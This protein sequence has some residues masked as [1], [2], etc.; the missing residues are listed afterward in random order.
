MTTFAVVA[1]GGM[2]AAVGARLVARGARV[3]TSTAG[4]SLASIE[5]AK[6]AGMH[7]VGDDELATADV[8]LSI[9]PPNQAIDL[10]ERMAA[11]FKDSSHRPVYIDLNAVSPETACRTEAVVCASG[12]AFVDGGIIGMPPQGEGA[13]PVFYLSG[14]VGSTLDML[15]QHGLVA[16]LV[17]GGIGAASALKMSYAGITKGLIAIGAAMALA[18]V[19]SGVDAALLDELASSQAELLG[20]FR[21]AVPDML[22]KAYRWVPEMHEIAD[23]IG[24]DRPE[25][26]IYESV[27]GFY[28]SISAD[29]SGDRALVDSL[30]QFFLPPG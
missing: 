30:R 28:E 17:P 9:V 14:P 12:T 15:N 1:P 4:R 13:G 11:R 10:A 23:Y 3:L 26:G 29:L 27:A 16:K 8:F 25:R 6:A 21:K 2:G 20:R 5:R 18:A 19:R 22:P 24:A 7:A